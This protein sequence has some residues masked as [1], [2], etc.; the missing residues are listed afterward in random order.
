MPPKIKTDEEL[1]QMW[2]SK[3]YKFL[4]I[5]ASLILGASIGFFVYFAQMDSR[6]KVLEDRQSNFIEL[7]AD[8]KEIKNDISSIK[9]QLAKDNRISWLNEESGEKIK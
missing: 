9:L 1:E 3:M 6:V 2:D 7:K 5:T 8:V 4:G